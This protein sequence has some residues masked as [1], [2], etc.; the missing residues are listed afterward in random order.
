MVGAVVIALLFAQTA[1]VQV[2]AEGAPSC[3]R[4]ARVTELLADQAGVAAVAGAPPWRLRYRTKQPAGALEMELVDPSGQV[5]ARRQMQVSASECEAAAVAMVAVVERYFRGVA[6][7]S[8]APLPSATA[9]VPAATD[10]VPRAELAVGVVAALWLADAA[11]PRVAIGAHVTTPIL[12]VRIGAQL[13]LP[14]GRRLERLGGAATASE[15]VWPLRISAA[16]GGRRGPLSAWLGPDA[17]LALGFGRGSGLPLLDSGTRLTLA[18]GGAAAVQV[19]VGSWQLVADLAGYRH[20]AGR[21]FHVDAAG[22]GR[23]LVLASP[24]W[25]ALAGI[26]VARRF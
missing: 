6:W 16:F 22:G 20:T 3:P 14:P 7:T 15:T 4:S 9:V 17:L 8:G 13:V 11:R 18:L 21:T 1:P 12:P 10:P 26:G 23:Q 19:P 24:I 2:D 5:A 25:Q